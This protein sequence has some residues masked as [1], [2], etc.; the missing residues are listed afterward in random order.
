MADPAALIRAA[1]TE[2]I[3]DPHSVGR[4]ADDEPLATLGVDSLT[5]IALVADLQRR[6]GLIIDDD[7]VFDPGASISTLAAAVTTAG[8]GAADAGPVVVRVAGMGVIGPTGRGVTALWN[9]LLAGH[10]HRMPA[11]Y[12]TSKPHQVGTV[13]GAD[14]ADV[15]APDRLP[16]LLVAAAGD[17]LDDAGDVDR[18]TVALVVGT[19]SVGGNA[20]SVALDTATP[21]AAALAGTIAP[22]A[23]RAL[24]LGGEA[25]TIGS[26]SASGA[27]ALGHARDLLA[28]GDATH[29]LVVGADA[30]SETAFHGLTALRTLSPDGCRPFSA[31][32]RGIG[33]SE[34]AAAILLRRGDAGPG[35]PG[36]YGRLAGYGASG[37]TT[38]LAAPEAAGIAEAVR[39]ALDD[40]G[41]A[42]ERVAF[43]NAHGPGTALGDV[44][45]IDALREVF[46]DALPDVAITSV[47]GVLGHCQGAA[48][49]VESMACLLS[50]RH[51]TLTPAVGCD[52]L[53]PRWADLD[54]VTAARP[55]DRRT[56]Y[57]M[58]ISCGLGGV[59]TAVV[60]EA[61]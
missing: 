41:V 61:P 49:V 57:S 58:S 54:I 2:R 60:W 8:G 27:V 4:L 53:D 9:G 40:A 12:R 29:V 59:N 3:A 36:G 52:P 33:V 38:H 45:E 34:A 31:H 46:G 18:S 19:T 48:G 43:V 7:V 28:A 42:P 26:A 25:V 37:Y 56:G 50:A 22:R 15:T 51:A 17:A 55:L 35:D 21:D 24:G 11:P 10:G 14:P 23:A 20:L 16:R 39:R 44:A 13:P 32:R 6:G 5:L 30:V 47:K 1:L